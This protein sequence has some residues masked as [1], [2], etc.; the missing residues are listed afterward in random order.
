M[1]TARE[2]LHHAAE[3]LR[4]AAE[5]SVEH[6]IGSETGNRIRNAARHALRAG[7]S[8]L[9]D[10]DQRASERKHAAHGHAVHSEHAMPP[11]HQP[12]PT[13]PQPPHPGA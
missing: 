8:A 7:L 6:L 13:Q 3:E 12:M 9:D 2:S 1:S 11:A 4:K 10:A 5:A